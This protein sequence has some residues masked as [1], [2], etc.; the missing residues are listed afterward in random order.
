MDFEEADE[1]FF[2]MDDSENE[3]FLPPLPSIPVAELTFI[4]PIHDSRFAETFANTQ[5]HM[6]DFDA[7]TDRDGAIRSGE[8]AL[9]HAQQ[10][11][12]VHDALRVQL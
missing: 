11:Q 3:E 4:D 7:Y 8:M 1:V 6:L 10:L 12:Y 2:S 5:M 9:Q